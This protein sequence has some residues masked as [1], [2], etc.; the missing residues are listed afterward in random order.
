M[1]LGA[2]RAVGLLVT[3]AGGIVLAR[4]LMP[5]VFGVYAII[6]FAVGLGITFGDLGLS[7]T[8]TQ[9]RDL[10]LD[11]NLRVAFTVHVWLTVGLGA[12]LAIAAPAIVH[13]LGLSPD[14]ATPLRC[15]ALLVPLSA[16]K[17]PTTVLLERKLNFLP[18]TIAET[19]DTVMFYVIA[20]AAALASLGVWSLVLGAVTAR[21][22]GLTVLYLSARWRPSFRWQR[23]HLS[24][25][26][27]LGIPF[28]GAAILTFSR[29][30]VVPTLVAAWSGVA[31][32][33]FINL[34][35]ALASLPLQVVYIAGKV[36]FPALAQ[37]QND[38]RGFA[39]ATGRA[40]NRIAVILLPVA[41]LLLTGA[42][43]IVRLIF[44]DPWVEAVPALRLFCLSTIFGG[45]STVLVYAL[46]SL[47]RSDIVLRLNLFWTALLWCLTPILVPWLGFVGYAL[48]NVCQSMTGVLALLA[49]RRL[50]PIR[51]LPH[52]RVPL[53]AG[54]GIA[55]AF[56][57]LEQL[58]IDDLLSLI[59]AG[60][61]AVALYIGLIA[62]MGGA[63]WRT[64]FVDD[65][66]RVVGSR[67]CVVNRHAAPC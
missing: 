48:A 14:A 12:T 51:V 52:V 33:G 15:L 59:A 1:L 62:L 55:L 23:T 5:E 53:A 31:A 27:R 50:V 30:A 47:G 6:L 35:V 19:L 45:T 46:N 41:L 39:E 42:D 2:Q 4:L 37:I 34:A 65:W 28:Q 8:L 22:A 44:G 10:D 26:L 25:L 21:L 32:V 3:V 20:V 13:L 18:I 43:P 57:S 58:W 54:L 38:P 16:L 17:M 9:R 40:L 61:A 60:S 29:D 49:L 66:R 64:E 11:T 36:L 24:F 56:A 7:A 67:E 63:K